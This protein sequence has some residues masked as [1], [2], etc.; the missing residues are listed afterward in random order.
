M[1]DQLP[2]ILVKPKY[3]EDALSMCSRTVWA[4]T[5][6]G[7]IPSYRVGRSIRY[8]PDEVQAWVRAGCPTEPGSG[9]KVRAGLH[10]KESK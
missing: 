10:R 8:S 3:I 1:P 4:L 2:A 9:A 6:C 5:R 7:A